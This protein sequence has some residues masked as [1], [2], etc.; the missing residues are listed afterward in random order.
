MAIHIEYETE[1]PLGIDAAPIIEKDV[2]KRQV[3]N[4]DTAL[5]VNDIIFLIIFIGIIGFSEDNFIG[6]IGFNIKA[7]KPVFQLL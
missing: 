6:G 5:A 3:V 7:D 1:L 4:D 2:Y